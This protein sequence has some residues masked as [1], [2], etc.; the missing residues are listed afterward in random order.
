[1]MPGGYLCKS[2]VILH[3]PTSDW[4]RDMSRQQRQALSAWFCT[5][6]GRWTLELEQ[7][8]QSDLVALTLKYWLMKAHC[9]KAV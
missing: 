8:R 3:F 6:V 7:H 1:M 9:K 2:G 5:T 4:D